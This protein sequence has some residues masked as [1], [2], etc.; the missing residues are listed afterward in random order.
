MET[1]LFKIAIAAV[2]SGIVVGIISLIDKFNKW[3][4]DET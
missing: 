4:N 3:K 1:L 2:I